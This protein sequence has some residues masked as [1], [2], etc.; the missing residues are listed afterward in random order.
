MYDIAIIGAGPAGASAALFTA[1]AGKKTI[2]FDNDKSITK[3]AWIENHY[4]VPEISGPDL[5][6]TGKKQAAKFGANLVTAQVTDIQKTESGFRLDT[7]NGSYEAKHVIFATGVA[8]DLAEKIGLRTKPATEPRIK[9]VIAV[10]ENGK[11][12]IDGI[13]AAGTV[14]GTSVHTII[15]AGDGAKVAI[16]IISEL[17]GERYVDHDVLKK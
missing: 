12:N 11:T 9:T 4:G 16:N 2:V 13:W 8:T 1:K 6:E 5:I 10:D 14:A 3:R 15:T 7:D 17:N